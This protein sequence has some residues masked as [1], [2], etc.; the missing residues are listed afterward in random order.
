MLQGEVRLLEQDRARLMREVKLKTE[1][2]VGLAGFKIEAHSRTQKCTQTEWSVP[3]HCLHTCVNTHVHTNTHTSTCYFCAQEG[4]A[5]RGAKQGVAIKEGAMRI[6]TLEG[7]LAQVGCVLLSSV[8]H[9]VRLCSSAFFSI[10]FCAVHLS[11]CMSVAF[12]VCASI[13]ICRTNVP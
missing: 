2:E 8:L 6:A 10:A 12:C 5:K 7:S 3:S 1:L 13:S 9:C 4:Y 11:L